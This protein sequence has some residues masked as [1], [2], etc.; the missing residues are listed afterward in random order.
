MAPVTTMS[1][2]KVVV[3]I[4]DGATPTEAFAADC[5]INTERGIQFNVDTNEFLVPD[6]DNPDDPA[7]KETVKDGLSC[8]I[9]GSGLMHTPNTE[10]WFDWLKS[11]DTKNCRVVVNVL[12]AAGGGYWQGAFH[13]TSFEITGNRSSKAEVSVTLVSN[14]VVTWTDAAA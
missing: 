13:L 14:G 7:W 5:M 4:G 6:C 12:A 11:P 3:Q 8:T 9:N 1:G 10:T 2:T